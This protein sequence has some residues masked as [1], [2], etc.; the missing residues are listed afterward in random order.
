MLSNFFQ[1][2]S[3]F[4][5]TYWTAWFAALCLSWLGVIVVSRNQGFLAAALAQ[6]STLGIAISL[7]MEWGKPALFS[8]VFAVAASLWM[9]GK[10]SGS[11]DGAR[12]EESTVWVF[13]L[14]G[15]L[16]TLLL[17]KQ[18]F[19]LEEIQSLIASSI[20]GAT[21][22]NKIV[23][24]I[25][26]IL[27]GTLAW[28]S[29]ARWALLLT[30]SVMAVAI[31]MRVGVWYFGF[32]LVLGLLVGGAT[33]TLGLLFTFGCLVAPAYSARNMSREI[34]PLF[35]IAPLVAT[36]TVF[37][38]L[39]LSNAWDYPPGQMVVV[40]QVVFL[41]LTWVYREFRGWFWG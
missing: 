23:F 1:S 26:A 10:P 2:F 32:A 6:A 8:V 4:G 7:L 15:S 33:Q 18:P 36:V 30:D 31:G 35:W 28:V 21:A 17:S 34:Q 13:L 24:G 9:A 39:L 40:T 38:G 11:R 14:G 12:R 29:R 41:A 3:L 25:A 37:A 20:M 27:T 22:T 16:S 19:G 5:D